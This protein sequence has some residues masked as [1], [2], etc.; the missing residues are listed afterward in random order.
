MLEWG[1]CSSFQL[2]DIHFFFAPSSLVKIHAPF[3]TI[4]DLFESKLEGLV[5]RLIKFAVPVSN[6]SWL[7]LLYTDTHTRVYIYTFDWK[8]MA[9]IDIYLYLH[10]FAGHIC[11]L[12]WLSIGLCIFPASGL[13]QA[14]AACY[15]TWGDVAGNITISCRNMYMFIHPNGHTLYGE[16][17][18]QRVTSAETCPSFDWPHHAT[19]KP[20]MIHKSQGFT[21]KDAYQLNQGLPR[22]GHFIWGGTGNPH[23]WCN[24]GCRF[25]LN[26]PVVTC[27][28]ICEIAS[29]FS[30][31]PFLHDMSSC[32]SAMAAIPLPPLGFWR[33]V[34]ILPACSGRGPS[35]C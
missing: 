3:L 4:V 25:P 31:F 23:G 35:T 8:L 21:K 28:E 30:H 26:Q 7:W 22:M 32:S 20:C 29:H 24:H 16:L 19:D 14:A 13:H 18:Y 11:K 9:G 5:L 15:G 34:T 6:N 12:S 33:L 17:D 27:R 2:L 1:C 10:D